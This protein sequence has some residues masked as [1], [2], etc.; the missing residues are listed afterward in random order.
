[1]NFPFRQQAISNNKLLR[2]FSKDAK[3]ADLVW[4]RDRCDRV[5]TIRE[6]KGWQLQMDN[7][8]PVRLEPGKSYSIPKNTYHR[9]LKGAT[10]L[11]VEIQESDSDF[12][13]LREWVREVLQEKSGV[14]DVE[15]V[16]DLKSLINKAIKAKKLK[17]G[18]KA[19]GDGAVEAVPFLG[20]AKTVAGALKTM[21]QLPDN[22]RPKGAL[23]NIDVDDDI[24]TMLDDKIENK[25]L[26]AMAKKL[27][28]LSNDKPLSD[29]NMTDILSQYLG[30]EYKGKTVTG[31]KK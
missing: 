29:L 9:I 18:A 2:E 7:Q 13:V 27:S 17:G 31:Y 21:Y 4:H 30:A 16:G 26:N 8:L 28:S 11:V 25:F 3:A 14:E 23:K 22:A 20:A 1:M 15:T 5:V 12:K 10:N 19:I 24:S 6:G